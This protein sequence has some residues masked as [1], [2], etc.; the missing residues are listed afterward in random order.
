LNFR[1]QHT[2]QLVIFSKIVF[3]IIF[4]NES[5][6]RKWNINNFYLDIINNL[7][8]NFIHSKYNRKNEYMFLTD[9]YTLLK[10]N[11]FFTW[12][13]IFLLSIRFSVTLC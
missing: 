10:F 2:A 8:F 6:L 12:V 1:K 3:N 5:N 9:L 13:K 11:L 4:N 7:F